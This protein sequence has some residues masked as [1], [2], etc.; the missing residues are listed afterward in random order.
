L[1]ADGVA[2]TGGVVGD[3]K[4]SKNGGAPAA[5]NGSATLT[6][7]HTGFYSLSLTTSDLDTVGSAEITIDD[8]VN[9]MPLKEITVVEEAVYDALFAASAPGFVTTT[10]GSTI[11]TIVGNIE[12]R[13]GTPVDLGGG[14]GQTIAG[15]LV[16]IE[17]QTDDIG[18][19]GAGLTA[20]PWNA[21]WDAE[22]QSECAD[23]INA[24][25]EITAAHAAVTSGTHGNAALKTLIDTIDGIVDSILVDTAEIGTAGAGLSAIP[26]N[27]AWDTEVQ[28]EATDALNA[29]DPPTH[30]ELTTA[31]GTAD[32]AVLAQVALVK[33]K[34]DQLTF[35]V[36][37]TLNANIEYVNGIQVD[38]VGSEADPWG[39]V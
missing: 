6:H 16:D 4:I 13:L 39:P 35:G 17:A 18:A 3:L 19:A 9:A 11:E 14:G 36:T 22:V 12:S 21:S 10:Q 1:D 7:R 29:Y 26:W 20:I 32:D 27:A 33:A 25:A 8:T 31:L 30:A 28:S 37:N 24:D 34:T 15:N 5:L 23:A 38:G 2:V